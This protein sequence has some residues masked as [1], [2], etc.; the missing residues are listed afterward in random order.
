ME[1]TVLMRLLGLRV[2]TLRQSGRRDDPAHV[3]GLSSADAVW[4]PQRRQLEPH[5]DRA[6]GRWHFTGPFSLLDDPA[7]PRAERRPDLAVLLVGRGGHGLAIDAWEAATAPPGWRVVIAGDP[8]RWDHGDVA[9]IGELDAVAPLLDQ[10]AVVVTSAGW[11]SVA[12][13]V[14]SGARLVV[15][16]ERRPFDEQVVRAEALQHAGLALRCPRWPAPSELGAV[17]EDAAILRPEAWQPVHDGAGAA[18]AARLVEEVH[19]A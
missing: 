5:C 12:D 11:A 1:V 10:A 13:V 19:A 14:A 16:P 6:D 9:S 17:L 7:R 8:R 2:V 15:V 4:V 3:N 18:R